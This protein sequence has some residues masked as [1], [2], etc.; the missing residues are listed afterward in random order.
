M[1]SYQ[2]I[3][4]LLTFFRSSN[5][6]QSTTANFLLMQ[7]FCREAALHELPVA[8]RSTGATFNCRVLGSGCTTA[9]CLVVMMVGSLG[10]LGTVAGRLVLFR[11]LG[12]RLWLLMDT[13]IGL[14]VNDK[15][16]HLFLRNMANGMRLLI[17]KITRVRSAYRNLG[18]SHRCIP[19]FCRTRETAAAA[20]W[21]SVRCVNRICDACSC[22]SRRGRLTHND[23][24][25][26]LRCT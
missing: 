19:L 16:V 12:Q 6:V 5:W 14:S 4:S 2:I 11:I 21:F 20:S 25:G 22:V 17:D 13:R 23:P 26:Y 8:L 10:T 15:I 3:G 24:T 9:M 18:N 7:N 1:H